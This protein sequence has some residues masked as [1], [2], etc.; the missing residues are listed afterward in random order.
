MVLWHSYPPAAGHLLPPV[1]L[2]SGLVATHPLDATNVCS[3]SNSHSGSSNTT[4]SS[5]SSRAGSS[6]TTGSSISSN[7]STNRSTS[8]SKA[9]KSS[10]SSCCS[11]CGYVASP[12]QL[13]EALQQLQTAQ[14]Q[15][16]EAVGMMAK[17]KPPLEMLAAV[18]GGNMLLPPGL[19]LGRAQKRE[20][21]QQVQWL[22][23]GMPQRQHHHQQ[24]QQVG[25]VRTDLKAVTHALGLFQSVAAVRQLYLHGSNL[26]LAEV[27]HQVTKAAVHKAVLELVLLGMERQG[28]AAAAAASV[29]SAVSIATA[30][31]KSWGVGGPNACVNQ[32][33][34]QVRE[35]GEVEEGGGLWLLPKQM[36]EVLCMY[37]RLEAAESMQ[38][39]L[40]V[41]EN[42]LRV[43]EAAA[44]RWESGYCYQKEQQ[45][46]QEKQEA[47][48]QQEQE[49]EQ[50]GKQQ[51]KQEQQQQEE[52]SLWS[53]E[54]PPTMSTTLATAAVPASAVPGGLGA[55]AAAGVAVGQEDTLLATAWVSLLRLVAVVLSMGA[56]QSSS[57][58][59]GDGC[60]SSTPA[61]ADFCE[62]VAAKWRRLLPQ[63]VG[64][65]SSNAGS[66]GCS[67]SG[68]GI[69]TTADTAATSSSSSIISNKVG[70]S[71]GGRDVASTTSFRR[72]VEEGKRGFG[73][74][75]M[76]ELVRACEHL[77]RGFGGHRSGC[78]MTGASSSSIGSTFSGSS[79]AA[80]QNLCMFSAGETRGRRTAS[81]AQ[82]GSTELED[83]CGLVQCAWASSASGLIALQCSY[84]Q[85]SL[86]LCVATLQVVVVG[87][88]CIMVASK[89]A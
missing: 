4:S 53:Q 22:G 7:R 36:L 82:G 70:N 44:G 21:Q 33:F 31:C 26:L 84:P 6:N 87:T 43:A 51:Q 35:E 9:G 38:E 72:K 62:A 48:Q 14:A 67:S 20:Q 88:C 47:Q 49:Q 32:G 56:L 59:S 41:V 69:A 80:S 27:R 50:Q 46:L 61:V 10:G 76:L 66:L 63:G 42:V 8:S 16:E 30:A 11:S 17:A 5:S 39:L 29:G 2:P 1:P 54:T 3:S 71:G 64:N 78:S 65:G 40:L 77:E 18:T 19:G 28:Q 13:A 52:C 81:A 57:S 74:D 15:A 34:K 58:S 45:Q 86:G 83:M 23:G 79:Q 75:W 12:Q 60:A 55:A 89:N 73:W 25:A 68:G 24:Q 37:Y 85:H